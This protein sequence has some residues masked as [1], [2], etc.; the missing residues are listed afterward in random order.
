MD[1]KVYIYVACCD[2]SRLSHLLEHGKVWLPPSFLNKA[3]DYKL[4]PD[5]C[6]YLLGKMLLIKGMRRLADIHW[7]IDQLE[8]D[9]YKKPYCKGDI[10]FNITHSGN[11]VLCAFSKACS[12]GIDIE[13]VQE[14]V[15]DQFH[16]CFTPAEWASILH[17]NNQLAQFYRYWTK[18]EA[19]MKADG[20]G[21][22]IPLQS[23]EVLAD[24]A[25]VDTNKWYLQELYIHDSYSAH[26]ATS[27]KT[28]HDNA[29][30]Y[31][32]HMGEEWL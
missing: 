32:L 6:R 5:A 1:T 24:E 15:F 14:L 11:Y 19:V 7:S 2:K 17:T 9:Q 31:I 25:S 23:F 27:V 29:I 18:K 13:Q 30:E 4:E 28:D 26:I 20:R 16:G 3:Y 21:M 10:N 8:F 12:L 22:H